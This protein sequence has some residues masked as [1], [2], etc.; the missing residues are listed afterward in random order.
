MAEGGRED[1]PPLHIWTHRNTAAVKL[2]Y[3]HVDSCAPLNPHVY[4]F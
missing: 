1:R 4:A 3:R 2:I